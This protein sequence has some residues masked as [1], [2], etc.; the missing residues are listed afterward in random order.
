MS[1]EPYRSARRVFWI[2][3]RQLARR[4][5]LDRADVRRVAQRA[6]GPPADPRLL[7]ESAE[8]FFSDRQRKALT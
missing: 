5:R 6:P 1:R 2:S 7:A 8:L 4:P 3:T